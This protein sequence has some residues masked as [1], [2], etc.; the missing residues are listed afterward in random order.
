M[1]ASAAEAERGRRDRRLIR[2]VAPGAPTSAR[3]ASCAA[4]SRRH[5]PTTPPPR[6]R[7]TRLAALERVADAASRA[8]RRPTGCTTPAGAVGRPGAE[9]RIAA[10]LGARPRLET[11]R[12][13]SCRELDRAADELA[14]RAIEQL[15]RDTRRV[16]DKAALGKIDAVIGQKRSAR[17]RGPGPRRRAASRAE[18]HGRLWEQGLIGD[19][20]EYWPFEGEYWADEYEG[21]R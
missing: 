8:G 21:W 17:H 9:A 10:D 4:A 2:R 5:H 20:E 6:P 3:A 15:Y 18:L 19:D 12:R 1:P 14:Q 11:P 16:L 13:A 7:T